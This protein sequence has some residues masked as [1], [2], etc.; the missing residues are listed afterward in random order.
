MKVE[1]ITQSNY[2]IWIVSICGFIFSVINFF[3]G[4]YV[5]TKITANDLTYV[6]DGIIELKE[7]D[8]DFK[9]ELKN[10][11][12]KIFLKLGKIGREL[13]IRKVICEERHKK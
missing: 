1:I 9:K 11:L 3:L 4:K 13:A 6:K 2:L 5:A 8:K 7:E 10:E 12:H